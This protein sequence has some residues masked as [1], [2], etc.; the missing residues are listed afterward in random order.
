MR[1]AGWNLS[2]SLHLLCFRRHSAAL[3]SICIDDKS[4]G[5]AVRAKGLTT[6]V[7]PMKLGDIAVDALKADPAFADMELTSL[8][9]ARIAGRDGFRAELTSR[10]ILDGSRLR[11]RHVV[12]GVAGPGGV[13]LVRFDA[14]AIYFF[15]RYLPD[16]EALL[17]TL[18]LT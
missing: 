13:Y 6:E 15:D 18:K 8:T 7:D 3:E 12:Y 2:D 16:F 4:L 11:E 10:L 5:D 14:P 17:P 9:P 1:P